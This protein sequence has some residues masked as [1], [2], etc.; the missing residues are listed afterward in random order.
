MSSG[1]V[2]TAS[3]RF[4]AHVLAAAGRPLPPA[5]ADAAGR[6][7][8]NVLG[9]AVGAAGTPAVEALLRVARVGDVVV[10]GRREMVSE[11]WG[12][13][14]AG[15]AAHYDDYDDTHLATV[16]HPAAAV[17]ATMLSLRPEVGRGPWRT[18]FA[19]GC[20]AELRIGNAISPS[21][22]DRGWHIT[23]TC[24]VFASAVTA[25]LLLGAPLEPAL[26][27]VSTM[28]VGHREGF[29][30]M[31]K[32]F[33]PGKAAANGVLAARLALAGLSGPADP[34]G[35]G[36]VLPVF[37]DSVAGLSGPWDGRWELEL[38]A[39]KPYPCGIVAHPVIDAAVGVSTQVGDPATV[40]AVHI[41]CHPLVPELMGRRQPAD[42]LQARFSAY[43]AAAVGLLDGQVGLPQFADTRAVAPDVARLR[44]L[45]TLD[46]T[47]TCA[48]DAATITVSRSSGPPVELH[49]PHARGSIARPLT[50]EE[51][52]DKVRRLVTPVIGDRTQAIR[53]AVDA[54]DTDLDPLLATIRPATTRSAEED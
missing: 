52:F 36:G 26:A 41:A 45:I 12:A 46:P 9:T 27:L 35:A 29:G 11:Y 37:A 23:G 1:L 25:A 34:L 18:A 4:C 38:N 20:E 8:F 28:V 17:L 43:H 50:D 19:V 49:V 39:F 14:V 5:V 21:H 48:R 31:T 22:Y 15:T 42:G 10:P 54:L 53:D 24:G 16:I 2:T 6:S 7:L 32:P 40:T 33:H 30:S 51:L 44:D 3:T 13:L 47:D